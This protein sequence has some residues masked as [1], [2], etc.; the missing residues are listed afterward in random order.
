MLREKNVGPF[1]SALSGKAGSA[2]SRPTKRVLSGM[3]GQ[4][5]GRERAR[6]IADKACWTEP[7]LTRAKLAGSMGIVKRNEAG[8]K[9]VQVDQAARLNESRGMTAVGRGV[10]Y[11]R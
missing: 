6:G 5:R 8:A 7:L 10:W 9:V 11:G 3:P 2:G 4:A 1:C